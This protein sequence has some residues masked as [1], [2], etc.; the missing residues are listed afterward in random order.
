M[1]V[2]LDEDL[3]PKIAKLLRRQGIDAVSA[4][5]VGSFQPDDRA[6]LEYATANGRAIVTRN[7]DDFRALA[8]ETLEANASHAGI[9]LVPSSFLGREFA[10]IAQTLGRA[11]RAHPRGLTDTVL[12]LNRPS[13]RDRR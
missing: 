4:H 13:G 7:A 12:Y 9:I 3:S 10:L 8:L 6:Q 11:V 1:K 2:Y 5:E